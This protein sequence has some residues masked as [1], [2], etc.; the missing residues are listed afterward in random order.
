MGFGQSLWWPRGSPSPGSAGPPYHRAL[1]TRTRLAPRAWR[2]PEPHGATRAPPLRERG[3]G[4]GGGG[5]GRLR[6]AVASS[7]RGTCD[8]PSL[9]S[10]GGATC[11]S[12]ARATAPRPPGALS[13]TQPVSTCEGCGAGRPILARS[14]PNGSTARGHRG[15]S[16]LGQGTCPLCTPWQAGASGGRNP[17]TNEGPRRSGL[18]GEPSSSLGA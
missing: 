8:A 1:S 9:S 6:Q 16:G 11:V 15:L 13:V 7:A 18:C 3:G 12:W 17:R 2:S 10:S 4:L 14:Y 5:T